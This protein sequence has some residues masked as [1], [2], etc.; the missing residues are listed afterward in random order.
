MLKFYTSIKINYI[1][2]CDK[3]LELGIIMDASSSVRQVNYNEMKQF[4]Q[5]LSDEFVVSPTGVHF[6][7]IHF[8]WKAHLDFTMGDKRYW[9]PSA[10]KHKITSLNYTYGRFLIIVDKSYFCEAPLTL[11]SI[12]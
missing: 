6:G 9:S 4:L 3:E 8:S 5:M 10:L 12:L 2:V 1:L 11:R 7:V